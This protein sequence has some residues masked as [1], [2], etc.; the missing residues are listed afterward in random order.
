MIKV[1]NLTTHL[2]SGG[3]SIYILRLCKAMQ[4]YGVQ[5]YVASSGG[6]YSHKFREAGCNTLKIDIKTKN[7]YHPKLFLALPKLIRYIKREKIQIIHAHTRVTQMLA[8]WLQK[9]TG[10]KVVTTA[11]GFYRRKLGR[12][13]CPAWGDMCIAISGPVAETLR[14]QYG[15]KNTAVKVIHNAID[16]DEWDKRNANWNKQDAK[17]SFGFGKDDK[18]IGIIAR[19][20][21]VKGQH[22]LI[23]AFHKLKSKH[24]D[25]KLLIV[26]EGK[27]KAELV[28][29][30]QSFGL[31]DRIVFAGHV[32]DVSWA[33]CAIDLF[34]FP[35][36]WREPFGFS[37]IEAMAS[38]LPVITTHNWALADLVH[39]YKSAELVEAENIDQLAEVLEDWIEHPQKYEITAQNGRR[40]AETL[41]SLPQMVVSLT[42]AYNE[43]LTGN[44]PKL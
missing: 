5:Y 16:I 22:V 38:R 7:E 6:D 10:V 34:A 27:D 29:L 31:E 33:L 37:L 9:F 43:V 41:F 39:E 19:L 11:H 3:I 2:N 13:L 12:R 23:K 21:K 32:D 36:T 14:D 1:L 44:R 25:I 4:K 42:A 30:T 24:S 8:F 15:L 35:A 26:G 17:A 18:V 28:K 40:M 20:E